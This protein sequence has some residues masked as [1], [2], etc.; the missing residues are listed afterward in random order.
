[1]YLLDNQIDEIAESLIKC[2]EE[3]YDYLNPV[4]DHFTTY[5]NSGTCTTWD[6]SA[7]GCLVVSGNSGQFSSIDA[8]TGVCTSYSCSTGTISEGSRVAGT[9]GCN[10]YNAPNTFKQIFNFVKMFINKQ[11]LAKVNLCK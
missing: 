5:S 2:L 1:M 7:N 6:C 11:T 3:G 9:G 10:I 4:N 8:C